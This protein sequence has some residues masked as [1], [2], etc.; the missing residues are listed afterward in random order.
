MRVSWIAVAVS[1]LGLA[2]ANHAQAECHHA[3]KSY[4]EKSTFCQS[5]SV[6]VCGDFGAWRKTT[7]S[8]DAKAGSTPPAPQNPPAGSRT[9]FS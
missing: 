7:A 4:P 8:C 9:P 1:A 6:F 2:A 5:G 3:H